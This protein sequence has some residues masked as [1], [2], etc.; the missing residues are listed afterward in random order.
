M[1]VVRI[2]SGFNEE[3]FQ[4]NQRETCKKSCDNENLSISV[5]RL[6]LFRFATSIN[7][8]FLSASTSST[9]F[10][11]RQ[12]Y[13]FPIFVCHYHKLWNIYETLEIIFCKYFTL[14]YRNMLEGIH[15]IFYLLGFKCE[16]FDFK[17]V[18]E[19]LAEKRRLAF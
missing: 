14:N 4:E 9:K 7:I 17:E 2:T 10:I 15:K 3:F 8:N 19:F 16:M 18:C 11:A 5:S 6:P 12:F 13:F 1:R